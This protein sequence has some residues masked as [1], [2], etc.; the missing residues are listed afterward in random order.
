MTSTGR[1]I[2]VCMECTDWAHE[3]G[4]V[5]EEIG[6]YTVEPLLKDTLE[7][8]GTFSRWNLS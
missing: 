6:L 2:P 1:R 7:I 5:M 4:T 8:R 3:E